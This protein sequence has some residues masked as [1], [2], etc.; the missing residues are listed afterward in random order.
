M[1]LDD[2]WADDKQHLLAADSPCYSV[3]QGKSTATRQI[4]I[5]SVFRPLSQIFFDLK[6]CLVAPFRRCPSRLRQLFSRRRR[7]RFQPGARKD[8]PPPKLFPAERDE[9]EAYDDNSTTS[10]F[11]SSSLFY[12]RKS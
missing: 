10:M 4:E 7:R 11:S 1:T 5:L 3:S 9:P 2:Q 6:A 8:T 12:S